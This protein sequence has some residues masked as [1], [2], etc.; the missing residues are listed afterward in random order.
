MIRFD[1]GATYQAEGITGNGEVVANHKRDVL[2]ITAYMTYEQAMAEFNG[3]P[4]A[5]VEDENVYDKSNYILLASV[6]DNLDGTV[7]VRIGRKNTVEEDLKDEANAAKAEAAILT[8]QNATLTAENAALNEQ[9]DELI[10]EVLEG[11]TDNV[12]EIEETV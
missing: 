4:W 12:L 9:Y 1:N 2:T 5:I 6:C 3:Q 11:G 10:V 7:T 8:S